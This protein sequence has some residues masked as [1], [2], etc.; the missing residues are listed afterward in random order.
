MNENKQTIEE[1]QNEL[2]VSRDSMAKGLE[3]YVDKIIN[4]EINRVYVLSNDE[5]EEE[6]VMID[7]EEYWYMKKSLRELNRC[8]KL[9]QM[10]TEGMFEEIQKDLKT[11]KEDMDILKFVK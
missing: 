1:E 6:V 9:M 7:P 8:K 5:K 10:S 2:S 4:K 11:L 3:K